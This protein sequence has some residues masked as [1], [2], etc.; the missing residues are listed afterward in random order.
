MAYCSSA[1][2]FPIQPT[3]SQNMSIAMVVAFLLHTPELIQPI[4]FL[5]SRVTLILIVSHHQP[6]NLLPRSFLYLKRYSLTHELG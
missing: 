4:Q 2:V 1:I 6:P 5:K 3:L